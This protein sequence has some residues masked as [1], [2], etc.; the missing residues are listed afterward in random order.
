MEKHNSDDYTTFEEKRTFQVLYFFGTICTIALFIVSFLNY[1]EGEYFF[2]SLSISIAFFVILSL[3]YLFYK[4]NKEITITFYGI[5]IILLTINLITTGGVDGNG[6][7]WIF[8][9]PPFIYFIQGV[10]KGSVTLLFIFLIIL[11]D[12]YFPNFPLKGYEFDNKFKIRFIIA[13]VTESSIAFFAEYSRYKLLKEVCFLSNNFKKLAKTDELTQIFNRRHGMEYLKYV[14]DIS[15]RSNI[16]FSLII[17]D[18]DHFKTVND[19]YGHSVGDELLCELADRVRNNIRAQDILCRWGGEEF[20]LILPQTDSTRL[21]IIA[22]KLR[23]LIC[24]TPF[25][26]PTLALTVTCSFGCAQRLPGESL[27]DLIGRADQNLYAA[28]NSGRN[29]VNI[30]MPATR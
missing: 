28:K 9:F 22:E 1:T 15:N 27:D 2:A 23:T 19:T 8:I 18:I 13:L 6:I 20:L 7:L 12:F 16:P 17:F 5:I 21:E 26:A 3:I 25:L 30:D 4:K 10:K 24:S 14:H 29:R 11:T